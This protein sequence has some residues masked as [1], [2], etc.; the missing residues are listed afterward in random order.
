MARNRFLLWAPVIA[1]AAVIFALSSVSNLGT[2]LGTWDL[3]GRKIAHALEYALLGALLFRA[4]ANVPAAVVV[5]SLYAV[6]D[7]VHQS[8][9]EGRVG[10]PLDWGIDTVGVLLGVV[11]LARRR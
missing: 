4:L 3:V 11:L 9:V 6:T 10:S 2:D 1:W 5:G 8:F 7:E